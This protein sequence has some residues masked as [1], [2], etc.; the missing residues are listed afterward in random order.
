MSNNGYVTGDGMYSETHPKE[1]GK[2]ALDPVLLY[3]ESHAPELTAESF[4]SFDN[5][6]RAYEVLTDFTTDLLH[7]AESAGIDAD[8]LIEA[9]RGHF[10]P[11]RD[12]TPA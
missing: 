4:D 10:Y 7:F 8:D 11:E 5:G 2:R 12:S 9:A 3:A 1:K 6:D